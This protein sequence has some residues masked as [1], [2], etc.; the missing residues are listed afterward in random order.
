MSNS[1]PSS[2]L[3]LST[4]L[5]SITEEEDHKSLAE[6][7]VKA[8]TTPVKAERKKSALKSPKIKKADRLK[9]LEQIEAGRKANPNL[10]L[11]A[12]LDGR[13]FSKFTKSLKRPFDSRLSQLMI[14]TAK[15]LVEQ[16]HATLGYTQSDEISLYWS[17]PKVDS[18]VLDVNGKVVVKIDPSEQTIQNDLLSEKTPQPQT[19]QYMFDGKIQKLTST[20][21]AMATA[22]FVSNLGDRIPEKKGYLPTFDARVWQVTTQ[23]EAFESFGWRQDDAIKNSISMAAFAVFSHS[24]LQKKKSEEKKKMLR[25]HG[26]P[27]E[28]EPEFFKRGTFVMRQTSLTVLSHEQLAKIPEKHRPIGPV[29]R[30]T[31]E[32]VDFGYIYNSKEAKKLFLLK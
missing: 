17:V 26:S 29:L 23:L 19:G 1:E 27:W 15:Y 7:S 32:E 28:D 24:L 9:A 14:D 22:F 2:T 31:V 30:T 20:L 21:A 16:T 18:I 4:D 8:E 11:L 13:S 10:P 12:R 25:D 6:S 5:I 3:R